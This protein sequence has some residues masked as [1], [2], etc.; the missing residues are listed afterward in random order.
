MRD[1]RRSCAY[2]HDEGR[3]RVD[4]RAADARAVAGRLI[5]GARIAADRA[6]AERLFD[7]LPEFGFPTR[8]RIRYDVSF[9]VENRRTANFLK[10]V[11]ASNR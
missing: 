7:F 11:L 4:A 5:D 6:V 8:V 10:I 3:A 9:R 2:C 1:G